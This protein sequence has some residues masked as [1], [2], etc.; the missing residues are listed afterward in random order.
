MAI[1]G[2]IFNFEIMKRLCSVLM[3]ALV[4]VTVALSATKSEICIVP[5][6]NE[7]A[8]GKG[9]FDAKGASFTYDAAMDEPSV[10]VVKAFA[11]QLSMVSGAENAVSAGQS[12][13]GFVFVMNAALP[14]EAYT[15]DVKPEVVRVEAS[16]LRGFNYAV[17]SIKQLLPVE[18]FAGEPSPKVKWIMPVVKIS[19]QPRFA[20]RGLHLDESRHF[21]GVE[22]V[23]R[24][25]DIMEV[26]KLNKFH[27]H[28]TDDQ[29]W[30]I[31]IKK[32]PGLTE[33][34]SRRK[35]TCIKKEWDNLD[36]VPYGEGM[37]YT[38]DQIREIVA[39]A[40]AKG[41]D[42]IPEIDLP[43]HMLGALSAYPELGC[44]GGPYEVWTRWGVSPDVLCAGNEKVYEFLEN[45]L[46]EVCDLFPYEYIHIGGDEC[47]KT[48]W[49]K[50][51]KCQAKIQELGLVDKDGETAEH[52]LQSYVITRIEQ[53][54][55]SKG[56]K[57]IGWDEI[58]EGGIA[59]NATIMSWHGDNPGWKAA[60]MGHD[61]IMTPNYCMYFDKYQST[62]E[63]NEPF[64]IGGYL[65]VDKV[66]AYDPCPADMPEQEKAHIL[67][68][69]ANMWTEYIASVDHLYY[70]LL[71]R[72]A[73]LSEVQW[74]NADRKDWERFYAVADR[75]CELYKVMGYNYAQ[76]VLQ[77]RGTVS[78]DTEQKSATIELEAQGDVAVR[79]T[80]DGSK[81]T[82]S[83]KKYKKPLT[84]KKSFMLRAVAFRDDAEPREFTCKYDSHKAVGAELQYSQAP[85]RRYRYG[86]PTCL[87]D[88]LRATENFRTASWAAW[89]GTPV[90]LTVDMK[91][92]QN[93]SSVTAGVL[94]NHMDNIFLP[95]RMVVSVSVDGVNFTEV[96][97]QSYDD[98]QKA[99]NALMD[100]TLSFQ[101]TSARYVK[102]TFVPV[103]KMPEWRQQ[104]GNS[105]YAFIDEIIVK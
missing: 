87:T 67:G 94:R 15:L 84:L 41:I 53:F 54:I 51:P 65:P 9:C 6:P 105:A 78:V 17:Q 26:Y 89:R 49:E 20:Y 37:W 44:T 36:G 82:K 24:Y 83:S 103:A 22:E 95:E 38:Q 18:V 79:Y 63:P 29:G 34:G 42:I 77:A 102:L 7:I 75:C 69:Q 21:F 61:A 64:G 91:S 88:G 68:V 104:D 98:L 2:E 57:I 47:P 11:S 85:H 72:L 28:L 62:D 19:D 52:Y 32:Y 35:G 70:M 43:G 71:P 56:R 60:A 66:Y 59:P 80:L 13:K 40:A 92:V 14:S 100:L 81:P 4:A 30:R 50:C 8:V 46:S 99:P 23:K 55:N 12:D 101:E 39:Y 86:L 48:S 58:L 27:W 16:S 76:H 90:D 10:N 33:V 25:L 5:Y 31:E 97:S 73:A 93:V 74:C 96:A 45:V 3:A 1:F